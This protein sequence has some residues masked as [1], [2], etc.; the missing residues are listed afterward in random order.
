MSRVYRRAVCGQSIL[1]PATATPVPGRF[2]R[3][4]SPNPLAGSNLAYRRFVII[5]QARAGTT[6][7]VSALDKH[8]EVLCHG[9]VFHPDGPFF[10][11]PGMPDQSPILRHYR[12]LFPIAFMN[13]LVFRG[14]QDGIHAVGFKILSRQLRWCRNP[15]LID[16]LLSDGRT[17]FIQLY[18]ENK[19]KMLLSLTFAKQSGVWS[20]S[21]K[22]GKPAAVRLDPE[23]CRQMFTRFDE[24]ES[25]VRRTFAGEHLMSVGYE[26]LVSDPSSHLS[27]IQ[28]HLG[29]DV[30]E[31]GP[32]TEKLRRWPE[33]ELIRNYEELRLYFEGTEW[34]HFFEGGG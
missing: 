16:R 26:E 19:L 8:P 22:L 20:S 15:V 30:E 11:V 2:L 6:M 33:R 27:K 1:P 5:G 32:S 9:E 3:R 31:I 28:T 25:F 10:G 34:G 18:R 17:R 24:H 29:L 21:D 7:L 4:L 23:M 12:N 13:A 14:L